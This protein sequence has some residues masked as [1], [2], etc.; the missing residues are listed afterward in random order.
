MTDE[1]IRNPEV[2]KTLTS[3]GSNIADWGKYTTRSI[4]SNGQSLQ[5]HFYMNNATGKIDYETSD[6]KVKGVVNP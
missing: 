5:V 1:E 4:R 3:D 2:V 6:F